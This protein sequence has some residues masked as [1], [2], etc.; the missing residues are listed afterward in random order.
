MFQ[1]SH[2]FLK[3]KIY[4]FCV[5]KFQPA[6]VYNTTDPSHKGLTKFCCDMHYIWQGKQDLELQDQEY[7]N[8]YKIKES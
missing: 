1:I 4:V 8:K 5:K 7:C 3:K 2:R 6:Y